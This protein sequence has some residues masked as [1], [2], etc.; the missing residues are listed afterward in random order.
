MPLPTRNDSAAPK[1]SE[2]PADLQR[3]LRDVDDLCADHAITDDPSIIKA[4]IRYVDRDLQEVWTDLD[5]THKKDAFLKALYRMYPGSDRSATVEDLLDLVEQSAMKPMRTTDEV[6]SYYARFIKLQKP[7][8]GGNTPRMTIDECKRQFI[9]AFTGPLYDL[10]AQ[11]LSAVK[12]GQAVDEPF[13]IGDVYDAAIYVLQSSLFRHGASAA[14]RVVRESAAEDRI[15]QEV[16]EQMERFVQTFS[17]MIG[18]K[19]QAKPQQPRVSWASEP[20]EI[21]ATQAPVRTRSNSN[22]GMPCNFCGDLNCPGTYRRQCESAQN[23]VAKKLARW[24]GTRIQPMDRDELPLRELPG[25]FIRD[26]LDAYLRANPVGSAPPARDAPP[27]QGVA[28]TNTI[29]ITDDCVEVEQHYELDDYADAFADSLEAQAM[30]MAE[31]DPVMA[32]VFAFEAEKKRQSRRQRG[33]EPEQPPARSTAAVP[34]T[35]V[36]K[37]QSGVSAPSAP[38]G[39]DQSQSKP[40]SKPQ[41]RPSVPAHPVQPVQPPTVETRRRDEQYTRIEPATQPAAKQRA[42]VEERVKATSVAKRFLDQ[43]VSVSAEEMFALSPDVRRVIKD[44]LTAKRV[45]QTYGLRALDEEERAAYS[46]EVERVAAAAEWRGLR[47]VFPRVNGAFV[48][49]AVLDSGSEICVMHTDTWRKLNLPLSQKNRLKMQSANGQK[50][51]TKGFVSDMPI[52]IGGIE[53]LCQVYVVDSSPWPMLLGRPFSCHLRQVTYDQQDGSQEIELTDPV[54]G[55]KAL[56][57]TFERTTYLPKDTAAA[58]F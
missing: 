17:A 5:T 41:A 33:E 10:M 40:A 45:A 19:P 56:I 43:T 26:K 6:S 9:R 58:G 4:Y 31:T 14:T 35:R 46:L 25:R 42:P 15:K 13:E 38:S 32:A 47:S 7:L 50:N 2:K 27:H 53:V 51:Q 52:L 37:D 29:T 55:E 1:F 36:P 18:S 21:P 54:T 8:T 34:G 3:Y 49:E 22:N 44:D 20:T 23:Y 16:T 12:T 24:D 39:R 30:G 57:P 48:Q 11:R 28:Q